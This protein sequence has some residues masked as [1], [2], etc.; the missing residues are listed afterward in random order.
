[1]NSVST[2][3]RKI[4]V[5]AAVLFWLSVGVAVP[6][7]FD[8][9]G[10]EVQFDSA[11]VVAAP[12][13]R[14]QITNTL[15]LDSRSGAAVSGGTL[16]IATA[17]G[18][19][20]TAENSAALLD[21]GD[22]V[23]VLDEGE[24]TIGASRVAA[25]ETSAP[26]A[27]AL[28]QGRFKALA[29]RG[30]TLIVVLPNGHHE[31]LTRANV[32]MLPANDGAVEVQGEGFWRG[33]RSKFTLQTGAGDKDGSVPIE[34]AFSATLLDF[35]Y[36]GTVRF[37]EHG[38]GATVVRGPTVIHLKDTER[39]A[40]ALGTSW[41]IGTS[42]QDIRIEGPLRWEAETLAF[43][44][45]EV[46]VG[47]NDAAG[48]VS[49]KTADGQALISSTLAFDKLDIAPYLPSGATDRT[50]LAWQWWTKL[51]AT[52][53]QPAAPHINADIRLSAKVL[54]SGALELGPAA[55]T[56]S[57][58]D[59]KLSADIAEIAL[60]YGRATGQVSID[61]NRYIPKL[62]MRG[63]LDD[64]AMGK[65]LEALTGRRYIE[66]QGRVIADLNSKGVTVQQIVGDLAGTVE[67]AVPENGAIALSLVE[68]NKAH[69]RATPQTAE[70]TLAR[71]MRGTTVVED[72]EAVFKVKD[73]IANAVRA[74]ATH[75][76]GNVK[77]SGSL[78]LVR[79]AYDFR[80]LSLAGS[81]APDGEKKVTGDETATAQ[82]AR[83]L[84]PAPAT[85]T[86]VS[87][88]S[89]RRAS[90]TIVG[91][92]S[93]TKSRS[94]GRAPVI[95]MRALTGLLSELERFLGADYSHIPRRGL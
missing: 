17:K 70:E 48:T 78:D 37:D 3:K 34:L 30:S 84:P 81:A 1:M 25:S 77:A 31:R 35:N 22:A 74:S 20:L 52:L 71:V 18:Q 54:S 43:D 23:L 19:N 79:R 86:F 69:D 4:W 63:Q 50:A 92:T 5:A 59:G 10:D 40:N 41:P 55:A 76:E 2:R 45:A 57:M 87:V 95:Q 21:S 58:K 12:R 83:P 47:S 9:A 6:F 90:R 14:F 49:L 82:A 8:I 89:P 61:F 46:R 16:G 67:I 33:Q 91:S 24:L 29:M 94:E 80:L 65:W 51:V 88:K 39:L 60:S 27:R 44:Q 42:V 68:L 15:L 26:L 56:V 32:H 13:D 28:Q 72:L 73:G 75:S 64:I 93:S 53:S 38:R 62:A 36:K 66:G 7:M 85:G 11:G